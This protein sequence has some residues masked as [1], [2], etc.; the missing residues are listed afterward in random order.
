MKMKFNGDPEN[1]GIRVEFKLPCGTKVEHIFSNK[2]V[3][4]VSFKR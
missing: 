2:A 1:D 3:V 4:K